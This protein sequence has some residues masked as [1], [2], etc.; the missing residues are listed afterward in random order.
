MALSRRHDPLRLAES[1]RTA[2][3][4]ESVRV[5][6]RRIPQELIEAE[7]TAHIGA[8]P[9]EPGEHA[10][11]RTTRRNG[12]RE[13]VPTTRAGD[14][15]SAIPKVPTGSFLP[16]RDLAGVAGLAR[17]PGRVPGPGRAVRRG[18][19]AQIGATGSC[20]G[21]GRGGAHVRP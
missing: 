4:I 5:P 15:D 21:A 17:E 9:G 7:A 8:E 14:L 12:H 20:E 13:R 1:P 6:A 19:R 11:T 3:A 2:D 18:P 10:E 16:Y